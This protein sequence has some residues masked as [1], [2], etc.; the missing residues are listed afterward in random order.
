M[1]TGT[2]T[3]QFIAA[4][5]AYAIAYYNGLASQVVPTIDPAI[6]ALVGQSASVVV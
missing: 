1:A 4:G 2:P 5:E 3:S 6:T